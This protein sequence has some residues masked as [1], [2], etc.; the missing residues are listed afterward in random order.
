[1]NAIDRLRKSMCLAG[2]A[3]ALLVAIT[4]SQQAAAQDTASMSGPKQLQSNVLQPPTTQPVQMRQQMGPPDPTRMT[5]AEVG[6][7]AVPPQPP[8]Q[9]STVQLK[10][11]EAPAIS[12]D[13][14][15]YNFG[16]I[17]AGGDISHDFWFTNTGTGPLEIISAKPS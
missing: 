10:P 16:R 9:Q 4:Q 2:A 6:R 11:G 5:A 8:A 14:P 1:M 13:T 17:P 7:G 12:F 15:E 3:L